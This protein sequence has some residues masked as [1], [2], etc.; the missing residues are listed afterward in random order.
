MKLCTIAE[1][2]ILQQIMNQHQVIVLVYILLSNHSKKE[3]S[4]LYTV[5]NLTSK[6]Y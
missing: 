6:Y 4:N 3:F 1:I 2:G 5:L